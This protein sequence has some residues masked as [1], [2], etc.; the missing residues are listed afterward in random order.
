LLGECAKLALP[1]HRRIVAVKNTKPGDQVTGIGRYWVHGEAAGLPCYE[2]KFN[3]VFFWTNWH[4][5]ERRECR[6]SGDDARCDEF[7]AYDLDSRS[8]RPYDFD[9]IGVADAAGPYRLYEGRGL[10][11]MRGQNA[12]RKLTSNPFC[13]Q[14]C[15]SS[16][17]GGR[18][19]W[20]DGRSTGRPRAKGYGL[21]SH[22]TRS[23]TH[24][25][26]RSD[27]FGLRL[28][29]RGTAH[30]FASQVLAVRTRSTRRFDLLY[31]PWR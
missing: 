16:F 23:W 25:G 17:A 30:G 19:L 6:D 20:T 13:H 5:G 28:R 15:D 18:V 31:T 24:L 10:Y 8:L 14:F 27:R 7:N 1:R 22:V 26:V 29:V 9:W 12:R 3:R 11:L 21:R 4:T 2:C